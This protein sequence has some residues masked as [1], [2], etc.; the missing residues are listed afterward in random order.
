MTHRHR[1]RPLRARP[2]PERVRGFTLIEV[3]IVVAIVGI[4]AAIAYPAYGN[5]VRESRRSD[6]HLALL[7]GAQ[8]MERCR[9]T[10]FSYAACTIPATS[11][12][13]LYTI[14]LTTQTANTFTITAT[15]ATGG[16]QAQDS[17]CLTITLDHV[18]TQGPLGSGG[19]ESVCWK[20]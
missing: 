11:P 3:M 20:K 2:V 17:D 6:A 12:N 7:S 9:S 4:I 15:A 5:Y 16:V 18:G 13:E 10:S 8:A 19:E 1:S 14:A